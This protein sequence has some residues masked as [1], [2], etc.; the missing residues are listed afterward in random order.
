M[1]AAV[2]AYAVTPR[3]NAIVRRNLAE[4]FRSADVAAAYVHRPSYPSELFD[5]LES[6]MADGPR[7]VLDLGAGEGALARPLVQ[8][9]HVHQLDA[10]EISPAMVRVGRARPGG[11]H[12][13]LRWLVEPAEAMTA[14]GPYAL[15]T[16][17]A[18]LHWMDWSVVLPRVAALLAP[19]AVLA[20]VDQ[21]YSD[22]P[23]AAGLRDVIVRHSRSADF[24]PNFSLPDELSKLGLFDIH[25]RHR[26]EP[27]FIRQ[28]VAHY[29]EQFHSTAS[30]ARF[31]MSDQEA[32]EF[33]REVEAL[34]SS[35]QDAEGV[36]TMRA[37][38]WVVWGQPA[39]DCRERP[40]TG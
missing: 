22:L 6:L 17:G 31:L 1:L 16:A 27:V 24:D 37:T 3:Q 30:L 13:G 15:A 26:C 23:W 10:V 7:A 2:P 39:L 5:R 19:G 9:E 36:L 29:I 28:P 32:D 14:V 34:V 35:H 11:S 20:L 12:P 33:D 4:S 40:R 38:A 21:G 18:S 8:R 25:G